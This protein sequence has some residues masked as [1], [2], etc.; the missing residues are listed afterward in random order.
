MKFRNAKVVGENIDPD[1]YH[2]QK[3]KRGD[4]DFVIS[5]SEL[6]EFYYCS[7]RWIRGYKDD[8]DEEKTKS[9]NWG[10]LMDTLLLDQERFEDKYAITPETYINDKGEEKPWNWNSKSCK[11]WRDQQS[12]K[13]TIKPDMMEN[14][15]SAI[16]RIGEDKI[17]TDVLLKSK[18]QVMVIGEY[19][20]EETGL[21]IPCK[22]LID[23]LPPDESIVD[24]KTCKSAHQK[25]WKNQ[26]YQY[27]YHFQAAFYMDLYNSACPDDKRDEF[28]FILQE[29]YKPWETGRRLLSEE[30]MTIG[31]VNYEYALRLYCQC[32]ATKVWPGYDDKEDS[33]AINGWT[34][35]EPEIWM[36]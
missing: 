22:A 17:I 10:S 20:D 26:V 29:N 18:F 32:L 31:R 12:G 2:R 24:F 11:D 15:N 27:G 14:V 30:F 28:K 35:T 1:A 34:I 21:I 9:L 25:A 3:A 36:V 5:R 33:N 19:H 4:M 16:R 7:S 6:L 23:L 13:E 8:E